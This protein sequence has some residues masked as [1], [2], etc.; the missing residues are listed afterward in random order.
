MLHTW[1]FTMKRVLIFGLILMLAAPLVEARRKDKK[2]GEIAGDTFKDNEYGLEFKVHENWKPKLGKEGEKVRISLTQRNYSIPADYVTMKDYTLIPAVVV[3]IDTTTLGAHAMID[4]LASPNYESAQKKAILKQFEILSEP[5]LIPMQRSRMEIAGQSA[6]LWRVQAK[7]KKAISGSSGSVMVSRRYGG[8]VA[9][10]K[11]D[12]NI[13]LFY[14]AS[15][16]EF[17]EAV[18]QEVMPM[19]ESLKLLQESEG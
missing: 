18:M 11:F 9:A 13:V 19:I 8:A 4:S 15:E 7:Y 12:Q 10:V 1:G 2:A 3:F 6:L 14:V 5:E 17:F 16:F